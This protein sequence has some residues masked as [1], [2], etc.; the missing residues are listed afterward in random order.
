[1]SFTPTWP[2]PITRSIPS[3]AFSAETKAF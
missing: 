2:D 1:V 3:P